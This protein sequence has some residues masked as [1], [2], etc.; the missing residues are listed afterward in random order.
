MELRVRKSQDTVIASAVGERRRLIRH[1]LNT[2]GYASFNRSN[3]GL[4]LDLSELLDV[5]EDGFAVH[6]TERFEVNRNVSFCLD[7]PETKAYIQCDGRVVW[8][9]SL[10]RHGIRFSSLSS[11]ARQEIK[12]WILVNLLIAA[13]RQA[14]TKKETP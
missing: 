2:P 11:Q 13:T 5:S 3:A 6:T 1:K 4:S 8:N 7:L 12:K 14:A 9:D 10:G